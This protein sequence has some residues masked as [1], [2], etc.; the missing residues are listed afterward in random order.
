MLLQLAVGPICLFIFQTASVSGFIA[1]MIGVMGVAVI[2]ALFI[3]AAISGI[4]LL[5]NK[6]KH[7]KKI[8]QISGAIVLMFFGLHSIMNALN[9]SILPDIQLLSGKSI[10]NIFL[11]TLILTLSNPLTILF[12]AGVFSTKMAE[13]HMAKPDMYLYGLG[14]VLA[15]VVFLTAVSILGY[16]VNTFLPFVIIRLLNIFIGSFLLIL[17]IKTTI[18]YK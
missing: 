4:A 17:G 5:L 3:F 12:W 13:E 2:D 14:A 10:D 18:Y 8:L 1:A 7:V 6:Y 11:K 16:F 9:I 15:T